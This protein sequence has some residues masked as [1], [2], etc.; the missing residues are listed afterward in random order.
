M[1]GPKKTDVL[2]IFQKCLQLWVICLVKLQDNVAFV[3]NY[4]FDTLLCMNLVYSW[5]VC[6]D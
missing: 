1:Q 2:I 3:D 4:L 5:T 6:P